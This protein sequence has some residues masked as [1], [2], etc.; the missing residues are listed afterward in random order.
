MKTAL[1]SSSGKRRSMWH[2]YLQIAVMNY[3]ATYHETPGWG[4]STVFLGEIHH[5]VLD[6]KLGMLPKWKTT[7]NSDVAE[8]LQKQINEVRATASYAFV[9]QIQE[10]MTAKRLQPL[11][12]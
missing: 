7:P 4:S 8:Q 10:S 1:R 6:L 12:K 11:S 5:N 3:H 2:K 9:S